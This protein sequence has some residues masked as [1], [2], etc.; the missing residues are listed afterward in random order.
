ME[1]KQLKRLPVGI[2]NRWN[3]KEVLRMK[4][5]SWRRY[6][7]ML[8]F[9]AVGLLLAAQT[10]TVGPFQAGHCQGIAVDEQRG[11]IYLS[12]T[13]LL[14]KIDRQG[15]LLGSVTGL[16]GHLGCLTFNEADGRVYGSLEYKMDEIGRGILKQE[17]VQ[18]QLPNAW[19]IAIFDGEKIT[20]E[21]MDYTEPG[22]IQAVYLPTV[23]ADYEATVE[24]RAHRYGCSGIDGVSFGPSFG[25]ADGKRY[26]TCAYGIR[27]DTTRTDND[28]QVLL[29]YDISDWPTRY[30][31]PLGQENLH[32]SGP[33]QPAGTYF[34]YTGNTNWGVQN[35]TYD[36]RHHWWMLFVYR[37][38]KRHFNNRTLYVVDGSVAPRETE[39]KGMP[40]G[41]KGQTLSLLPQ[42]LYDERT[43]IYGWE[44]PYGSF[45][46]AALGDGSF[47]LVHP[48]SVKEGAELHRYEWTGDT[49]IPFKEPSE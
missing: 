32:Q 33:L 26:L 18:Q 5:I 24:G 21:G 12:F 43:G 11:H 8:A 20:R 27:G 10:L 49:P 41:E 35:L 19:Y 16:I 25:E 14:V 4:R 48:T 15:K 47:Y 46:A 30:E 44:S 36:A 1:K 29:Q 37:G 7:S 28:Y 22:V 17:G 39:L 13:T 38:M 2:Q 31:R 45:G 42:G 3:S 6:I 40:R 23:V 34:V 9:W